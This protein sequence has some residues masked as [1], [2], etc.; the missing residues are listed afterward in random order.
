L[1]SQT[2]CE[3]ADS[4]T[5]KVDVTNGNMEDIGGDV[6]PRGGVTFTAVV[7]CEVCAMAG[8]VSDKTGRRDHWQITI[9]HDRGVGRQDTHT[10]EMLM[11]A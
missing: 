11:R 9:S 7:E 8:V 2:T 10:H 4:P 1:R 5:E 3:R 6:C